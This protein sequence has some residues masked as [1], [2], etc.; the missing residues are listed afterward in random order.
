[1]K[2]ILSLLI[3]ATSLS[4]ADNFNLQS[5]LATNKFQDNWYLIGSQI[6]DIHLFS[7]QK[8]N[9][10]KLNN[11]NEADEFALSSLTAT[12][13]FDRKFKQTRSCTFISLNYAI[14]EWSLNMV[15]FESVYKK[16]NNECISKGE[17]NT[18]NESA[19]LMSFSSNVPSIRHPGLFYIYNI[20]HTNDDFCDQDLY[21]TRTKN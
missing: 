6:G 12:I 5:W 2:K 7:A 8:I 16:V 19:S 1:M 3:M 4:F 17:Y 15:S 21:D 14:P 9:H 10:T 20:K 11:I 18:L 13:F